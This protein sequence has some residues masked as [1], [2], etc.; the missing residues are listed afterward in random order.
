MKLGELFRPPRLTFSFI[1]VWERNF[2][3]YRKTWIVQVLWT[4][5]EPLM[6]LGA[7]GYGLGSYVSGME[8][9][10]YVEFLFPG[11]LCST[12]M[13]VS[14]FEG[15]YGSFTKLTWQKTYSTIMLTRI[16]PEEIVFGEVLWIATKGFISACGVALVAASLGLVDSWRIVP[17]LG[18][19]FV[20]SW[21]FACLAMIVTTIVRNYDAFVYFT[22]GFI[23]PMSLISGVYFPVEQLPLG[24]Q[25]ATWVLPLTHAVKA[26]REI[27]GA[28]A[29]IPIS[30]HV[31]VLFVL[32]W[33]SMNI[34]VRR[35]RTKLLK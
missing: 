27:L 31:S 18:V 30:I 33:I 21:L 29:P 28:G 35:L 32:G 5:I 14:F 19:L 16:S 6:Y 9:Q 23:I 12:A 17:V 2:L 11:I 10:S 7:I 15:T 25:Q 8:G 22:S 13:T 34:A 26:T 3:Y 20:V 24:L 1:R 4:V